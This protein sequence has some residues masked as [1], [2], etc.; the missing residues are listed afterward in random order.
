MYFSNIS[1][2]ELVQFHD[3]VHSNLLMPLTNVLTSNKFKIETILA[4]KLYKI[5]P[6]FYCEEIISSNSN[7]KIFENK[8]IIATKE[9][10][11]LLTFKSAL[12]IIDLSNVDMG[13]S[14]NVA[15]NGVTIYCYDKNTKNPIPN[16]NIDGVVYDCYW[17]SSKP[18]EFSGVTNKDGLF[19]YT[20]FPSVC[21]LH[22]LRLSYNGVDYDVGVDD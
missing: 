5:Y 13:W 7:D 16:V 22:H 20:N 12:P 14:L 17:G 11:T 10:D 21:K 1:D 6:L 2:D 4:N 18:H 19:F 9:A 3:T 15:T 8:C